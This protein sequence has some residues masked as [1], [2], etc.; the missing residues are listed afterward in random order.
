MRATLAIVL[1]VSGVLSVS[2]VAARTADRTTARRQPLEVPAQLAQML[3]RQGYPA[4]QA[5]GSVHEPPPPIGTHKSHIIIRGGL[6]PACWLVIYKSGYSVSIS[7]H[8]SRAAAK[9]AYRRTYNRW[10]RNT[11]RIAVGPLLVSGFRLS[12]ADWKVIV[13]IVSA[14]AG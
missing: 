6:V 10:E 14:V 4:H 9:L 2:A 1:L 11:R 5:C 8:S 13:R 7:P 3:A 12:E